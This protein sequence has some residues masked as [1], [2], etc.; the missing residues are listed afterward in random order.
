[1]VFERSPSSR[2]TNQVSRGNYL[3]W[4]DRNGTFE[5]IALFQQ[6]PMNVIAPEGAEQVVGLRVTGEF[7]DVLGVPPL[8]GRTLRSAE[9]PVGTTPTVVLGYA[10]WRRRYGG[11]PNVIGQQIAVDGT[12]QEVVGVMPPGF[13]FPGLGAELFSI[14]Q[15]DRDAARRRGGRIFSTVARLRPGV[16]RERAQAE[17]STIA[18][19]LAREHPE[20]NANWGANVVRLRDYA[21]GPV[22]RALL[23]LLAAVLCVL[24]IACANI[25][26]LMAMRANARAREM[27]VRLALGAGRWRLVHQ[28]AVESLLLAGLGGALGLLL[29]QAGVPAIVS[30]FPASFP[31]PRAHEISVDGRVLACTAAVSIGSGIFFGLLPGLQAGRGRVADVLSAG[32]R[33]VSA[34]SRARSVLVVGEVTLAVVLVVAA[35]LLVRSLAHLYAIDPGFRPERVL[36]ARMLLV[37]STY[38]EPARRA[39]VVQQMLERLRAVPGVRAAGSIHFLPLSG[40]ESGT[41]VRRLDRPEPPPGERPVAGTYV[42]APGYFRA[43][44]IPV[45]AGR[46]F[47]ER[48]GFQTPRVAM[49]NQSFVRQFFPGEDPLGKRLRVEWSFP[50]DDRAP[51]FDIVGVV[52][53]TRHA[54]LQVEPVPTVFLHQAQ[55]PAFLASLVV[56]TTDDPLAAAAALREQIRAVDPEQGVLSVQTMDDV[57]A[58]SVARPRLQAL[59]LGAFALLALLM[60]CLGLYGML[61]Y[62]VEQRRRELGLRVAI[63][64]A[65]RAILGLVVGQGLRLTATGLVIGVVLALAMTRFLA[66][67]LYGVRPTE[68]TVFLGVAV[69]LL[70]VAAIASFAPARTAMRLDPAVVLREE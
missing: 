8:L 27:N 18:A 4:R 57:L 46:D 6:L 28:L 26:C 54:A 5:R 42:V 1:M 13:A 44:G 60:T 31:L 12:P 15:F 17:M 20:F 68:P 34:G 67:L 51:E 43:M 36:T 35:G 30:L 25:A 16:P 66:A 55:E 58:D 65:P 41:G 33:A 47:E 11:V 69:L 56:R 3:D 62:A 61:A 21:V 19:Q 49:V 37:L 50:G 48:D 24:L 10:L 7:F 40:Q 14:L 9:E 38:Q 53:D 52:G 2:A 29:A 32:G 45:L 63:G 22:R 23:V 39:A 59:L 70:A 64:A